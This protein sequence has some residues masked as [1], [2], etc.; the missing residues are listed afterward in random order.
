MEFVVSL[1]NAK[2]LSQSFVIYMTK[3]K[4]IDLCSLLFHL[5]LLL[6]LKAF[7]VSLKFNV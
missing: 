4:M 1:G 7:V 2:Y 6:Y 3:N 5:L